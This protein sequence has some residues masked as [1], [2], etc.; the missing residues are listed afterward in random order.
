M[1]PRK[2]V[3]CILHEQYNRTASDRLGASLIDD[4]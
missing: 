4:M 3:E 2:G 1:Q